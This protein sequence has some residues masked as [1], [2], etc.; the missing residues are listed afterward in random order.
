MKFQIVIREFHSKLFFLVG[1][2]LLFF[3]IE[4]NGQDMRSELEIKRKKLLQSINRTT[5]ALQA[6]KSQKKSTIIEFSSLENRIHDRKALVENLESEIRLVDQAILL[7]LEKNL[8]LEEDLTNLQIEYK[9]LLNKAYRLKRQNTWLAFLFSA[10]GINDALKRWRYLQQFEN[11]RNRQIQQ[12]LDAK[13]ELEIEQNRLERERAEKQYLLETLEDQNQLLYDEFKRKNAV[14]TQLN[15][16][17][18]KLMKDLEAQNQA[19]A[20]LIAA[21][22][23]AIQ[24]QMGSNNTNL[25]L[26]VKKNYDPISKLF[27]DQKGRLSWPVKKGTV[28]RFFGRQPHPIVETIQVT[29]NGIDIRSMAGALE[30]FAVA[31]GE[32]MVT[33]SIPGLKESVLIKHGVFFTVYSN[34]SQ[35]NVA[36]GQKIKAGMVIGKLDAGNNELHFEIWEGKGILNPLYWL[37]K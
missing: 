25:E 5:K 20:K 12:L 22:E 3:F 24:Q 10:E 14:L 28:T 32:V 27:Y 19:K 26:S 34:I 8:M 1:I 23:S 36:A 21:I 31:E 6:T 4:S 13:T 18:Q 17:E 11:Y 7:T 16:K 33:P 9:R 37:R 35:L 15:R 29:N 30:V 2:F